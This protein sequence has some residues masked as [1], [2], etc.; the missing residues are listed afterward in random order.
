MWLIAG[1]AE[2]LGANANEP[3][4]VPMSAGE[5]SELREAVR[6][7]VDCLQ[8]ERTIFPET[9]N[10]KGQVV[11]SASYFDGDMDDY[12]DF[13]YSG[14]T[15]EA[16]PSPADKRVHPGTSW[17]VSH[18]ER[19]PVLLRALYDNKKATGLAFPSDRDI[20]LVTNQWMYRVFQGNFERPLFNNFFD[21]SNG[22]FRIGY[23]GRKQFGYPP[24]QYCT[25][26]SE[27]LACMTSGSV[28]GW[29]LVASFNPD[30][31][32]LEH[33]LATLAWREDAETKAFKDRYYKYI[34]VSYSAQDANGQPQYPVLLLWVLGTIPQKL[35]GCGA[36]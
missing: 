36:P 32:E 27:N 13:A 26:I 25:G 18:V 12:A 3:R 5:Y 33:A 10:F 9:R 20:E 16:F 7:G 28:M 24:A 31:M 15:G 2:M 22:W 11:G 29:G 1:A 19:L 14:Y 4:L 6:V 23:A 34:G 21:G 35:Q 8:K 30:L 17:D